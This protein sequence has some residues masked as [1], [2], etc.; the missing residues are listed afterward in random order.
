MSELGG[1]LGRGKG[2]SWENIRKSDNFNCKRNVILLKVLDFT[3]IVL[4]NDM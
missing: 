4:S 1:L 3:N 2:I